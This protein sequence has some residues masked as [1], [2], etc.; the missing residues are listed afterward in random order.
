MKSDILR[1]PN[2]KKS[3]YL[4]EITKLQKPYWIEKI[5]AVLQA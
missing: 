5:G 4:S 1:L 2:C 3:K